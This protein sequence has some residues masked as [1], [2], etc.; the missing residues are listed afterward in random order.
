[1]WNRKAMNNFLFQNNYT[2]QKHWASL[3][4][5]SDLTIN[6]FSDGTRGKFS[7]SNNGVPLSAI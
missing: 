6:N 5:S 4:S 2:V 7:P 3:Q 1:M